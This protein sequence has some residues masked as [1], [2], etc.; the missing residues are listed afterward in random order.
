MKLYIR[1]VFCVF[2]LNQQFLA[3]Q[4]V[5]IG[6]WEEHMSYKKGVSVAEGFGKVFCATE[7]GIFV[8]K[9]SD[10]SMEHLS[11]VNGLSDAEASC[12][13]Y[14][15]YNDKLIIAYKNSNIDIVDKFNNVTNI[16]DIKRKTI[17]GNKTINA[18]HFINQ[19]AYLSCGFGV[20]VIDMERMEVKDTYYIG[21]GG[22]YINIRE[23]TSDGTYIY[24]ATNTGVYRALLAGNLANFN[25][26]TQMAGLP[27]GIY[28]TIAAFGGK[29]YANYSKFTMTNGVAY[30]QDTLFEFD[31]STWAN[32]FS[33][34]AIAVTSLRTSYY[35][36]LLSLVQIWSISTFDVNFN[37]YGYTSGYFG[38]LPNS[39]SAIVD[40]EG[41]CW[42]ADRLHGL[43]KWSWGNVFTELYPNGPTTS[44]IPNMV[45]ADGKLIAA[46]GTISVAW[47]NTYKIDNV[48][49]FDGTTWSAIK[50]N[51][52]SVVNLDTLYDI[53]NVAFDPKNSNRYFATTWG[54][55]VIEFNNNVPVAQYNS[56]NSSLKNVLPNTCL[57]YGMAFDES[58]NLWVTNTYVDSSI[59]V[60]R[61]NG[62]WQALNFG[63]VLGSINM[64]Q[65]LIDKNDQ[66]W[67]VLPRGNGL[68]VYKGHT[69][70]P[71]NSSNTK[72]MTT[73]AGNGALPS[74]MV[75]CLAIDKDDEIWIGTDKG[76]G[77]FY[78]PEKVFT[79]QNFDA[80]QILIEQ[81]GH[82]QILLETENVT[83]IAVDGANRKWIGTTKSGVF[84][85]S[86][87][88][89]KQIHHF[90]ESN[91]PLLSNEILSIAI[92]EKTGQVYFSTSKGVISY[93][94]TSIEPSEDYSGVYAFPNPVKHDY[95]GPIAIKGL[96]K[97]TTI[98]VTDI[99]G[100]LVYE[101]KSEGGL[102]IWDGKTF[103]G[104]RVS[105]GVYMVFGTNED[106]SQKMVTKIL[107]IN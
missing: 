23:I 79:G 6:G 46:P 26:W 65:I 36:N 24:A 63:P 104:R 50:G 30:D 96:M 100:V 59:S 95:G 84:L 41:I 85:M 91:S 56:T 69:T 20:V 101:T 44:G 57:V 81:D 35:N 18:I 90:D 29:V 88:G 33:G 58:N 83:A 86:A 13:N 94:G 89:T 49:T 17:T 15:R 74:A 93:R 68:M 73:T 103:D 61:T 27:V 21:P 78:S 3:A 87:D 102:A 53:V 14:N 52:P 7:N 42:I 8:Y 37:Y 12:L 11:K 99:T 76:I 39:K 9:K 51:Y 77:V 1:I 31:G 106:G 40:D 62:T 47:N 72:K 105:S 4:N 64:G 34:S 38:D 2:F 43:V 28:N 67:V 70:N 98:K 60:R 22:T 5:P 97:N 80:Q 55:G 107:F 45:I 66:K 71:P 82:V 32:H 92:D 10:N 16:S 25:E 54:R 19:F 75:N 48:N